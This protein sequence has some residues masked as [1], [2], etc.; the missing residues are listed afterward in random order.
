GDGLDDIVF[1]LNKSSGN[2]IYAIFGKKDGVTVDLNQSLSPDVGFIVDVPVDNVSTENKVVVFE[3]K[4]AGDVNGDG[5]ADIIIGAPFNNAND[6]ANDNAGKSYILFGSDYTNS[7]TQQGTETADTLTGTIAAESF[8]GGFGD[9]ILA[10]G[11]GADVLYG[12]AG[13]DRIVISDSS[14]QRI[15]GG[16]GTDTL[17][18]DGSDLTLDIADVRG[19][20]RNVEH[21]E[22]TGSGD[23]TLDVK[24]RDLVNLSDTSNRLIVTGDAGDQVISIDQDW[25][26]GGIEVIDGTTFN[27]YSNGAAELL[28][29]TQ[30]TAVISA[31]FPDQSFSLEENSAA[32]IVVGEINVASA[33]NDIV[34]VSFTD[35]SG[36]FS[37]AFD[38]NLQKWVVKVQDPSQLDFESGSLINLDLQATD[39]ANLTSTAVFSFNLSDINEAPEFDN[40]NNSFTIAE[41]SAIGTSIGV[42]NATD[43]DADNS[44]S[45][46]IVGGNDASI[47]AIDSATGNITVANAAQ[48]DY[49]SQTSH[50]LTVRATDQDGLLQDTSVT[51]NLTDETTLTYNSSVAFNITDADTSEQYTAIANQIEGFWD[52]NI[53]PFL[54]EQTNWSGDANANE[55]YAF[56]SNLDLSS[57]SLN[58]DLPIDV[59]ILMPDG[60]AP[61]QQFLIRS[62]AKLQDT[63]T[64]EASSPGVDFEIGIDVEFSLDAGIE[65]P[66]RFTNVSSD[67]PDTIN[68]LSEQDQ[69]HFVQGSFVVDAPT[70]ESNTASVDTAANSLSTQLVNQDWATVE[71]NLSTSELN[72]WEAAFNT[73]GIPTGVDINAGEFSFTLDTVSSAQNGTVVASA[74]SY[75]GNPSV[76]WT[77]EDGWTSTYTY[78]DSDYIDKIVWSGDLLGGKVVV[79]Y[80]ESYFNDVF[81]GA[82]TPWSPLKK[83]ETVINYNTFDPSIDPRLGLSQYLNLDLNNLQG[84]IVFTEML[85]AGYSLAESSATF[86]SQFIEG[87]FTSENLATSLITV[88]V[89]ADI[90]GNGVVEFETFVAPVV[91]LTNYTELD[92]AL[93]YAI[94]AGAVDY[95]TTARLNFSKYESAKNESGNLWKQVFQAS[96]NPK[97]AVFNYGS[98][99]YWE[100]TYNSGS[101]DPVLDITDTVG[102]GLP[103]VMA[104]TPDI[105]QSQAFGGGTQTAAITS[106]LVTESETDVTGSFSLGLDENGN[107]YDPATFTFTI[108]GGDLQ[109]LEYGQVN[110]NNDGTF[111]FSLN[112]EFDFLSEGDYEDVTFKYSA[113]NGSVTQT[114]D[115]TIIVEGETD[116]TPL[117]T[118]SVSDTNSGTVDVDLTLINGALDT[119]RST[120]VITHGWRSDA[121]KDDDWKELVE[122]VSG[123]A[124]THFAEGANV[125]FADWTSAASNLVY[126]NA[127]E[128]TE[129]VGDAIAT[130]LHDAGLDPK[131]TTIIGHSLGSH[132]SGNIGEKW[133]S[134]SGDSVD[135]II[136]LDPAGPEF[137]DGSLTGFGQRLDENDADKVVAFH[138]TAALGYD[139]DLGDVDFYLNEWDDL[140]IPQPGQTTFF[141]D[142]AYPIELLTQ[143]YQGQTFTQGTDSSFAQAFGAASLDVSDLTAAAT[144][145][146]DITTYAV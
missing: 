7:I 112:D 140:L 90:D 85:A 97:R 2:K 54:P 33:G 119:S 144:G 88:P 29:D 78:T 102:A 94:Q 111:T 14:F 129:K 128:D 73:L 36:P 83:L 3:A 142:H 134:L 124:G 32:G 64:L 20:I 135:L 30:V 136:G 105:E 76:S 39:S 34:D 16:A 44:L 82:G 100:L 53:S 42:A 108:V 121:L 79:N 48:L 139:Y 86:D 18:L 62:A 41:H 80:K 118:L 25:T 75:G 49:E 68:L 58:A 115:V 96:E 95:T 113:T 74:G 70:L 109:A 52:D 63:A 103:L 131:T 22:L 125:I 110:N 71:A 65:L 143:L 27:T 51:I 138:S 17:A 67:I 66:N 45:Y 13:N 141:G 10:G 101:I 6:A 137:E 89:N 24:L 31:T 93:D 98:N 40:A 106:L 11:G 4:A 47:F 91:D 130:Y 84:T 87:D 55:S 37:T 72:L 120:Y 122:S 99:D 123:Y 9:D 59:Q 1:S 114:R 38:A 77:E 132:V 104:S 107:A 43:Q 81:D 15:D 60:I 145:S 116:Y 8:I 46:S 5:L 19:L 126:W 92:F 69:D 21:I 28:I 127:A 35:A 146:F 56:W 23:N 50:S 26:R 61:G 117:T 133:K 57:G 12:G